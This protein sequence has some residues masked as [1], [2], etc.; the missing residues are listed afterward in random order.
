MHIFIYIF[1]VI[2]YSINIK[3]NKENCTNEKHSLIYST[4]AGKMLS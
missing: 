4:K 2:Q 1:P 3:Q